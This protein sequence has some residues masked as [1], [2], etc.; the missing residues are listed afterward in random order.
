ML[1]VIEGVGTKRLRM[2]ADSRGRL[3]EVLRRDEPLFSGFGQVH[4]ATAYAGVVKAWHC[5]ERLTDTLVGIRGLARVALFDAR[6][7]SATYREI[8]EFLTG[9][10]EPLLIRVP[11]YVYHGFQGVSRDETVVLSLL[12]EPYDHAQPDERRLAAD[13]PSIPYVWRPATG[14]TVA[15]S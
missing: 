14:E 3:L 9:E 1:G 4:L 12:S 11:P 8:D 6:P 7:E 5:H 13:D 10:Q 2:V 15:P